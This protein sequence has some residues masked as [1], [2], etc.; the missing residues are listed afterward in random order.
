MALS[1]RRT[2]DIDLTPDIYNK[3][4]LKFWSIMSY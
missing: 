3:F 4:I 2:E 1:H